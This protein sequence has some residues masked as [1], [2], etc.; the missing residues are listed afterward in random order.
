MAWSFWKIYGRFIGWHGAI[1]RLIGW[2]GAIGRLIGWHGAI[3]R[4][5]DGISFKKEGIME[6]IS[7]VLSVDD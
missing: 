5:E 4:F 2:H 3:G 7:H 1:G 6:K